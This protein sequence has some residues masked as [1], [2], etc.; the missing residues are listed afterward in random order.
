MNEST[1]QPIFDLY[2]TLR[3]DGARF[4]PRDENGKFEIVGALKSP[5]F[6]PALATSKHVQVSKAA[7]LSIEEIE[8]LKEL[9]QDASPLTAL[10]PKIQAKLPGL[11]ALI[12][13]HSADVYG[14]G[15]ASKLD[16][17]LLQGFLDLYTAAELRLE[18][19]GG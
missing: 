7:H 4:P 17:Q 10:R 9:L 18:G 11:R 16:Q 1:M 13:R 19:K 5:A 12:E 6:T 8:E 15:N 2:K 3:K 14:G